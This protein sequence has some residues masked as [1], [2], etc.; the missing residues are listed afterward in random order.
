MDGDLAASLIGT[1]GRKVTLHPGEE[2]T[3]TFAF[4]WHF[5]NFRPRGL[6]G[7]GQQRKLVGHYYASRFD[8]AIAVADYLV[9]NFPRLSGQTQA[10]VDT[11]YDST[12][13]YW[14]LDR[15]MANTSTLA[16]TTCYRFKDGRFSS[17]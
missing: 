3:V 8:S 14:L 17:L 16:T 11:W 1:I 13:P 6:A 12:L 2:V 7:K 10:W 5:P 9:E 15:A 4:T